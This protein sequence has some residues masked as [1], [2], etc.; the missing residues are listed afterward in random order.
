MW[1]QSSDLKDSIKIIS[2]LFSETLVVELPNDQTYGFGHLDKVA[3]ILVKFS[4]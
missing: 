4:N 2:D 3:E 1:S